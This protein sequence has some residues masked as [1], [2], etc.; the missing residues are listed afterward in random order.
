MQ[1][2]KG[3]ADLRCIRKARTNLTKVITDRRNVNILFQ[4][5]RKQHCM[6]CKN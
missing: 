6:H 2:T 3:F 4:I 1:D 5:C